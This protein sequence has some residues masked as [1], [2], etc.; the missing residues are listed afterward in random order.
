MRLSKSHLLL[1]LC[2]LLAL[3][4]SSST[5]AHT[6]HSPLSATH[7]TDT[8]D[9][10]HYSYI[11]INN[12]GW[13]TENLAY[14]TSESECYANETG[15][16]EKYGRMYPYTDLTTACPEGWRVPTVDDW[17]ALRKSVGSKKADHWIAPGEWQ[18]ED[19]TGAD[20]QSGLNI[21]PGGRTD[22]NGGYGHTGRFG[23]MG[24]S[25]SF[26]LDDTEY[27]WHIRWGKSHIH[28]HG[29]IRQQGRKFYLRCVC[30]LEE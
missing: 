14:T 12:L 17:K 7:F 20:N 16:C 5:P 8:R 1:C 22:E 9:G 27:H 2:P 6:F 19:Y 10:N 23:E 3:L 29:D 11:P 24:I 15:N 26:W 18:G 28:K 13:M 30:E 21:L 25:S 4:M